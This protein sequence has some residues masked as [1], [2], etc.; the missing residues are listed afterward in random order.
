MNIKMDPD[1]LIEAAW[2]FEYLEETLADARREVRAGMGKGGSFGVLLTAS[3]THHDAF[4][5]QMNSAL[6]TGIEAAR[7]Y[8]STLTAIARDHGATDESIRTIFRDLEK[9]IAPERAQ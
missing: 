9:N 5:E 2:E 4:M 1:R 6:T 3:G 7:E 8:R